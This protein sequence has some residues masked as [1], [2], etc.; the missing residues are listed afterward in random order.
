MGIAH[1]NE[2]YNMYKW[3]NLYVGDC[4]GDV[5]IKLGK[6]STSALD[7]N[8]F[9]KILDVQEFTYLYV[10]N[11]AQAGKKLVIYYK[12]VIRWWEKWA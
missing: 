9:N 6:R 12:E 8:E 1:D 4:D 2:I 10:T 11:T 3:K 7:P 5:T